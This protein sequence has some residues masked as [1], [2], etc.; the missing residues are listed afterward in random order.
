MFIFNRAIR[1][2][3]IISVYSCSSFLFFRRCCTCS[4]HFSAAIAITLHH[5]SIWH[6]RVAVVCSFCLFLYHS[7]EIIF[8]LFALG[9]NV[10]RS[11]RTRELFTSVTN[12]P[13]ATRCTSAAVFCMMGRIRTHCR[14]LFES[15]ISISLHCLQ[16][17]HLDAALLHFLLFALRI[18]R[19]WR[20][21]KI[22]FSP[23]SR[24]KFNPRFSLISD[25]YYCTMH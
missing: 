13:S 8:H 24:S 25:H 23:S 6:G 22:I 11:W 17:R 18:C 7:V 3:F 9:Q 1:S 15:F 14:P 4:S 16:S 19:E 12:S 2:Q 10:S 20:R 21:E 5:L